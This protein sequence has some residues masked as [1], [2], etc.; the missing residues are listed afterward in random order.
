LEALLIKK[1]TAGSGAAR[2]M[3]S[4]LHKFE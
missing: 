3:A 2:D 1:D 4:R